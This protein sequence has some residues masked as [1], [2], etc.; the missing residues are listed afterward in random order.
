M[1]ESPVP[2][3]KAADELI[4]P[5]IEA[6]WAARRASPEI[7]VLRAILRAF[8]EDAG[9]VRMERIAAALPGRPPE[10][11]AATVAALDARD[12]VQVRE[13]QVE[14]AYPFSAAPTPFA[15]DLGGG[16]RYA[17]CAIDAIGIAPMLGRPLRVRS[18]CHHCGAPLDFAV[19]PEGPEPAAAAILV[20][21]GA[22]APG[23]RRLTSGL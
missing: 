2:E 15:V 5:R 22:H 6:R 8:A 18:A 20:W 3:I 9:P 10:E 17:C 13:G 23:E 14:I 1:K 4:D 21:V 16:E 19:A 7:D 12:L 11:V